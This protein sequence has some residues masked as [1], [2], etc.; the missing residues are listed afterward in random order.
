MANNY[1]IKVLQRLAYPQL[2]RATVSDTETYKLQVASYRISKSG[3]LSDEDHKIV[4]AISQ[5]MEAVTGL[6]TKTAEDLQVANYGIGGHYEAHYDWSNHFENS[7][8]E[9]FGQG[10][11]IATCLLYL[12]DIAAGGSTVFMEPNLAISPQ[13]GSMVF[14]YNLYRNGTGKENTVHAACPVLVGSKWV[15]NKW[16]HERG[17]EYRRPC[18]L[19]RT[20]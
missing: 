13:K 11:R 6:S 16:F 15:A 2:Q 4:S 17:Q 18:S 19:K 5:R 3:W 12:N 20:E 9:K 10:N 1:E 7:A 14:W 8:M